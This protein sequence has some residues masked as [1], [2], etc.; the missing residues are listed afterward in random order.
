MAKN[1]YTL[2]EVKRDE[3]LN[4]SD[5]KLLDIN[6]QKSR[7]TFYHEKDFFNKVE[8]TNLYQLLGVLQP[9]KANATIAPSSANKEIV[10]KGYRKSEV[11][12][13][14]R[15][16]HTL[17]LYYKL[18][19]LVT[20]VNKEM[21]WD[22]DITT[23]SEQVQY[24]EYNS[25]YKGFYEW[26]LDIGDNS[27]CKRKISISIQLSDEKEY[28]GGELEFKTGMTNIEAPKNFNSVVLFPSYLL[29]RVRPVTKGTRRSIVLWISGPKFK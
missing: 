21:N 3:V 16:K 14:P 27:S 15:N 11:I 18:G 7:Q 26:H 28:E 4:F 8:L 5:W 23:M 13:I 12:F 19:E 17:W 9:L 24:A 29:H 25:E 10:V 2:D 1:P 22:F 6:N 20:K